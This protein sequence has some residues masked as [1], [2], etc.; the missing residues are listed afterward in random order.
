MIEEFDRVRI[1]GTSITGIVVD[2]HDLN[3]VNIFIVESDKK[4]VPGGYGDEN[5]WK[6]FDCEESELERV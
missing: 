2:M 3:G 5:G 1:K 4:G 6:L